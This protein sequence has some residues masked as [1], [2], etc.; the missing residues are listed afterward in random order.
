MKSSG[1]IPPELLF[2]ET[3]TGT[4]N[5]PVYN[6]VARSHVFCDDLDTVA[7]RIVKQQVEKPPRS[8][9]LSLSSSQY[10]YIALCSFRQEITLNAA[11]A[12]AL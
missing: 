1:I 7:S 11:L 12:H 10:V 9:V 2:E 4:D 6:A 5:R 8:E 3:L